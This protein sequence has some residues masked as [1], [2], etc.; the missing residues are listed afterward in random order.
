MAEE[1][2]FWTEWRTFW[3]AYVAMLACIGFLIGLVTLPILLPREYQSPVE[4]WVEIGKPILVE[5]KNSPINFSVAAT[6]QFTITDGSTMIPSLEEAPF[7]G[8]GYDKYFSTP[9]ISF[10]A[11]YWTVHTTKGDCVSAY[12]SVKQSGVTLTSRIGDHLKN[13]L[14]TIFWVSMLITAVMLFFALNPGPLSLKSFLF[15]KSKEEA[16][17]L[18]RLT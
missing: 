15:K 9:T 17:E 4:K 2:H 13:T 12:F 10:P 14:L 6:C 11:G 18:N 16:R 5:S 3:V 7:T 8:W 1:K